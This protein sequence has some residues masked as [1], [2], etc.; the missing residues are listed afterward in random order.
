VDPGHQERTQARSDGAGTAAWALICLRLGCRGVA[1][2][3]VPADGMRLYI[4]SVKRLSLIVFSA[5][6]KCKLFGSI[7][8]PSMYQWS[9]A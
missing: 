8:S 6:C 2:N 3:K 4:L 9:S 7:L 1:G 5:S